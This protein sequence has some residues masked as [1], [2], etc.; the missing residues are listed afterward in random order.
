MSSKMSDTEDIENINGTTDKGR[1]SKRADRK[2]TKWQMRTKTKVRLKLVGKMQNLF[3]IKVTKQM[4][5]GIAIY[6]MSTLRK[7]Q[8]KYWNAHTVHNT[9]AYNALICQQNYM[10]S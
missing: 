6:A 4:R 5:D 8:T 2:L 7:N 1:Q 3:Q 10:T 9:S